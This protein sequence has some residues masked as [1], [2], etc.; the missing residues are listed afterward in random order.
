MSVQDPVPLTPTL[1]LA[2]GPEFIT[3]LGWPFADSFV[4]RL[5]QTDIS[6]RDEL[7]QAQ[8]YAYR[9]PAG[10]LV[11]FGVLDLALEYPAS[12]GGLPH[13]YIPL[14][15]VNPSIP[16]RGYGTS[17]VQ[18]LIG[19]STVLVREQGCAPDIYLDVYITSLKA[20][21]LYTRLGFVRID[22]EPIPDPLENGLPYLVMVQRALVVRGSP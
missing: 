17:I 7:S 5:L 10:H 19:E 20:I 21:A 16:S 2:N 22:I 8:I 15:A 11:G 3:I 4:L 18:H 6:Q 14:I 13:P 12:T 1:I 9:D